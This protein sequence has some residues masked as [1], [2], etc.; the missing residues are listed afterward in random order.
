MKSNLTLKTRLLNI[1]LLPLLAGVVSLSLSAATVLPAFAQANTPEKPPERSHFRS[2]DILNLTPEQQE[3]MQQIRQS[4]QAQID[5]IL[6]AE[7]K[8]KLTAARE[9]GENPRQVFGSLNLTAEQRSQMQE[10]KR[11]SR[12]QMDAIL[13]P[14]QRQQMQQHQQQRRQAR[15]QGTQTP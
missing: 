13:T 14:E 2:S 15:P 8:A 12:E 11:S 6:T 7:Q 9:N 10:I 5:N 1:K 4:S 3:K